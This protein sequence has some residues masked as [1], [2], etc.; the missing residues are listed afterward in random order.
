MRIVIVTGVSGAGK[1]QAIKVLED[2]D[3]FCVDNLPPMIVPKFLEMCKMSEDKMENIAIVMDLRA[4]KLFENTVLSAL[5]N[6]EDAGYN[7]E[8]LFLD[9]SDDT[10]VKRYKSTRR[11]HPLAPNDRL[12]VGIQK[13]KEKLEGIKNRANYVIDTSNLTTKKLRE[14]LLNIFEYGKKFEE[15]FIGVTSFGFKNGL[16]NDVDLV[17]D[18]RFL[19]NPYHVDSLREFTGKNE[20]I[21]EY[22]MKFPET[23]TLITK[24]MD[25]LDFVIPEYI[26]ERRAQLIIG[27]GCTGGKHRS[28]VIAEEI[29]K[30]LTEGG[31]RVQLAHRDIRKE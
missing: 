7:Y 8:I 20:K 15:L 19:P 28:V 31:H 17:F 4:G 5:S 27:I 10:L 26:K 22:V 24:I 21:K 16:P 29:A 2:M 25:Y 11:R 9:A 30:R 18:V 14:E 3:F 13:E 23:G 1:S 12:E 6:I